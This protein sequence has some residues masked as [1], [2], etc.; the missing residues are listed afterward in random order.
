MRRRPEAIQGP[1]P[2]ALAIA[3]LLLPLASLGVVGPAVSPSALFSSAS[4][5]H[6]PAPPKDSTPICENVVRRHTSAMLVRN[7]EVELPLGKA[8]AG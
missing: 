3:D 7:A 1:P 4:R 5:R 6:R 2:A 8:L